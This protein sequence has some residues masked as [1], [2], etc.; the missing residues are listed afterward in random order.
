MNVNVGNHQHPISQVLSEEMKSHI[1]ENYSVT[2]NLEDRQLFY[3]FPCDQNIGL[4]DWTK[5]IYRENLHQSGNSL[6]IGAGMG[7]FWDEEFL[8]EL[9]KRGSVYITDSSQAMV[10]KCKECSLL[11]KNNVVIELENACKLRYENCRFSML[12]SHFM[13]YEVSSIETALAEASRVLKKDGIA[14]FLTSPKNFFCEFY[15]AMEEF[16]SRFKNMLLNRKIH[17][18]NDE[19]AP[20]LLSRYFDEVTE[21]VYEVSHYVTWQH[22]KG[23]SGA[24]VAL[25][26]FRSLQVI[27]ESKIEPEL[28]PEAA[29]YLEMKI[30]EAGEK[31]WRIRNNRVAFLCKSP[32]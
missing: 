17:R 32:K 6:E 12:L 1:E 3:S 2:K 21:K 30:R 26:R 4:W 28:W 24:Q 29:K 31:G 13:M 22:P 18:F 27:K 15:E 9:L 19:T 7:N 20:E 16:D 8:A 11:Q 25:D 23:K 10:D 5:N 14:L